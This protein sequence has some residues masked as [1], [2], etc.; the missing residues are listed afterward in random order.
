MRITSVLEDGLHTLQHELQKIEKPIARTVTEATA[1]LARA[2]AFGLKLGSRLG[3]DCKSAQD[4]PP[5]RGT[6]ADDVS[7]LNKTKVNKVVRPRTVEDIRGALAYARANGLKVSMAGARHSMG[8]QA[9][10]ENGVLLD[11]TS[12]KQ[13]SLGDPAKGEGKTLRVQAGA[14]WSDVQRYLDDRGLS[15]DVMQ[16]PS[17]FT[18]GGTLSANAH[19]SNPSSGPFSSTVQSLRL[20]LPSGEVKQCSR[21]EN[22]E[23]FRAAIGGYGLMGVVVDVDIK[24]RDNEMYKFEHKSMDVHKFTSFYKNEIEGNDQVGYLHAMFDVSP[25]KGFLKN[26]AIYEY[27]K[28][29]GHQGALPKISDDWM[30]PVRE[31]IGYAGYRV[32]T[33]D[34]LGKELY[35][36]ALDKVIPAVSPKTTSR[37]LLMNEAFDGFRNDVSKGQTQIFQE[38]FVPRE[39]IE[40][41]TDKAREILKRY[42]ANLALAALR[43]VKQ[44][45]TPMMG[46]ANQR[47]VFGFVMAMQHD[48]SPKNNEKLAAM[49]RELV[50]AANQLG[51]RNYLTYQLAYTPEQ[52]R[53]NYP[54]VDGFFAVKQKYDPGQMFVNKWFQKYGDT[55]KAQPVPE[56]AP[57]AAANDGPIDWNAPIRKAAGM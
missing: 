41:F 25:G 2:D 14:M 43:G 21:T 8:G 4:A 44:D 17:F 34:R 11:M 30:R 26:M 23:L 24:V 7:L 47:D 12:F 42:D 38:Y 20:M 5:I 52:L 48:I 32:A 45:D 57:A 27:T 15:V 18:V 6:V 50:D 35:W 54:E 37:N 56:A 40:Q 16:T 28:D 19:G 29:D 49:T 36:E 51:G 31:V 22:P 3:I 53:K 13:M 33:G 10:V 55:S 46:Y 1:A 9:L 39:N